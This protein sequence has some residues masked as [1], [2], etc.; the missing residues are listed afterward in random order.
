MALYLLI[1]K[2]SVKEER[3]RLVVNHDVDSDRERHTTK[4]IHDTHPII[5][6]V[7]NFPLALVQSCSLMSGGRVVLV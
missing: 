4:P 1:E 2:S 3:L 6:T 5:Y 7:A